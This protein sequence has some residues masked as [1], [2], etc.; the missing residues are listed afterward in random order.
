VTHRSY[1]GEFHGTRLSLNGSRVS[2]HSYRFILHD[3]RW[4]PLLQGTTVVFHHTK[5]CSELYT[6]KKAS[7]N[8]V[9]DNGGANQTTWG[10][11]NS[12]SHVVWF[13]A[14]VIDIEIWHIPT[15]LFYS[16]SGGAFCMDIVNTCRKFSA[17]VRELLPFFANPLWRNILQNNP[18]EVS[19][20]CHFGFYFVKICPGRGM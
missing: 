7:Q 4:D 10:S 3:S 16:V 9:V 18:Q 11:E 2:L 6:I 15:W 20:C 13:C 5:L 19:M 1:S 14:T 12:Y 17:K 8:S